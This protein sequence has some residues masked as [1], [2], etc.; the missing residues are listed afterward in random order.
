MLKCFLSLVTLMCLSVAVCAQPAQADTKPTTAGKILLIVTNHG[1]MGTTDKPTG[2][3]LSE[4]TH[5]WVR[6]RDAG[7]DVEF[8][9]PKGGVAPM[10]PTSFKLDDADNKR[11]WSDRKNVEALA[12]TKALS[13]VNAADYK[14]IY[15]AGGHGTMWDLPDSADVQNIIRETYE[16]GR[17]VSAVCHG[18]AALVNVKLTNGKYLVEGKAL[19]TFTDNEETSVG[20]EK[21]VPFMLE[22]KLRERGAQVKT[23]P[24]QQKNVVKDGHLVTGQN[25]ASAHGVAEEVIKL[26]ANE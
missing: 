22:T 10:D 26:L 21:V 24:N 4:V 5:A 6:F 16:A 17:I 3:Y 18:P 2:Y 11:F 14:A 15:F 1:K 9:S 7:Y 20:L 8:A 19:A 23:A 25:P 12:A 13:A